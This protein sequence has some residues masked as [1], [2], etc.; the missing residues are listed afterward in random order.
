[1][2]HIDVLRQIALAPC[3]R[4]RRRGSRG[5]RPALLVHRLDVPLQVSGRPERHALTVAAR[6]VPTLLVHCLDVPLQ[7][8][9]GLLGDARAVQLSKL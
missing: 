2:H 1:V 4:R 3:A 5:T 6:V 7:A 9:L 8:A